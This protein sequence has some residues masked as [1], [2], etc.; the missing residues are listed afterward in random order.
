MKLK[1][2][3]FDNC[4]PLIFGEHFSHDRVRGYVEGCAGK[5]TSAG[6]F[7]INEDG[8]VTTYDKS[9]SLDLSPHPDDAESLARLFKK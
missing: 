1:Y 8:S 7:R 4:F 5:P 6:F 9:I 2:V 3:M